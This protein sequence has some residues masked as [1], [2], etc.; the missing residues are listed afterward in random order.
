M[1]PEAATGD[2]VC[3]RFSIP[4]ELLPAVT[5]ALEELTQ[6]YNWQQFGTMTPTEAAAAALQVLNTY[7]TSEGE[8]VSEIS[9]VMHFY[10]SGPGDDW[11]ICD[12]SS[13]L[14]EDY[15][16]LYNRLDA[17]SSTLILDADYF[18][19]PDLIGRFIYGD[20]DTPNQEGGST[21]H[22]LTTAQMPAH[23]HTEIVTGLV[24]AAVGPGEVPVVTTGAAGVTGSTGGGGSHNNMPPYNTAIPYMRA[25]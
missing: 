6:K 12:G 9:G 8:C 21:V 24:L 7:L 13:Y 20:F 3:R 5:G 4:V 15:P 14:R 25:R 22:T 23:T 17:I 18:Q 1:T 11:L 16:E 19:V 2:T 10:G